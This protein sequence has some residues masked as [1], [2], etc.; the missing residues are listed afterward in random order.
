[1]TYNQDTYREVITLT[2]NLKHCDPFAVFF[3][4]LAK[5]GDFNEIY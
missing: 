2:S 3:W 5:I 1:M 4:L